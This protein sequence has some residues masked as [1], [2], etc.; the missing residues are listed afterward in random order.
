MNGWDVTYAGDDGVVIYDDSKPI[1][2]SKMVDQRKVVISQ[3]DKNQLILKMHEPGSYQYKL[4]VFRDADDKIALSSLMFCGDMLLTDEDWR[5]SIL[6]PQ[7]VEVIP[8]LTEEN[9][10]LKE[11]FAEAK[12]IIEY[13]LDYTTKAREP[14]FL[15]HIEQ[16]ENF[17]KK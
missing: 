10:V 5:K 3:N 14:D 17:L 15:V 6:D 9:R 4:K 2:F 7:F 11:R 8:K 12:E 16:A 13:L 1:E